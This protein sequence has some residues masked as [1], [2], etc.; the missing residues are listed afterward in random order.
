MQDG[1][2]DL[3]VLRHGGAGRLL[4]AGPLQPGAGHQRLVPAAGAGAAAAAAALH[5]PVPAV[6]RPSQQD[7]L[8][9]RRRHSL[10]G[11]LFRRRFLLIGPTAQGRWF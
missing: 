5:L 3:L 8:K 10:I 7:A 6:S 2:G 11:S 4:P 9:A 1:V